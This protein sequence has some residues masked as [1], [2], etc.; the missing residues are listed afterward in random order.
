MSVMMPRVKPSSAREKCVCVGVCVPHL[1]CVET[2]KQMP[3][4]FSP[5][6]TATYLHVLIKELR[7]PSNRFKETGSTSSLSGWY[8]EISGLF[9]FLVLYYSLQNHQLY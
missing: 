9:R 1:G 4:V 2:C 7:S 8:T 6:P 5:S 3:S